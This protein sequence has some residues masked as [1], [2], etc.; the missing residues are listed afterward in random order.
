LTFCNS[1]HPSPQSNKHPTDQDEWFPYKENQQI[2]ARVNA[3]K[4]GSVLVHAVS[5]FGDQYGE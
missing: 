3:A 5:A 2:V 1:P 4:L